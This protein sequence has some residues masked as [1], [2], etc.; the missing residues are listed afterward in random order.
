[1]SSSAPLSRRMINR[2]LDRARLL[3]KVRGQEVALS[4]VRD[5]TPSL[6]SSAEVLGESVDR[7]CPICHRK[8]LRLTRWIHSTWLGE[9]SGTARNVREIQKVLE[10]FSVDHAD[11]RQG[12]LS[13]HTVE[14]C[15]HCKWNFLIRHEDITAG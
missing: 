8:S 1:M 7:P 14:V 15:L 5:A 12:E 11:G 2:E 9:K 4:S 10:D 6:I 3:A 13:I